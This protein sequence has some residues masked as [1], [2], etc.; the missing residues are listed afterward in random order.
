M[1]RTAAKAGRSLL[2]TAL[3]G[4]LV[5]TAVVELAPAA[6][7]ATATAPT[8][9]RPVPAVTVGATPSLAVTEVVTGLANP[10]DL[11]FLPDGSMIYNERPGRIWKRTPNGAVSQVSADLSDLAVTGEVGLMGMVADPD[12]ATNRT[13]YTCQGH[14]NGGSN[15]ADVRVVRWQFNPALTAATRSGEP[16]VKGIPQ[17]ANYHAGCRLRF[18]NDK[19]LYISTGDTGSGTAPQNLQS[20][21]GKVLRVS[22]NGAVPSGNP[23]ASSSDANTRLVFTRGH[24]NPQGLALR[25]GTNEM[26]SVEQGTDRD[27]EIN[28]LVPGGNY[29][30]NPRKP[31]SE[32]YD[33]STP[34]TN[35]NVPSAIA[36]VFTTGYPT[37]AL[38]GGAWLSG[39]Q[40]G[41]WNG[42]F[43]AAALKNSSIRVLSIAGQQTV[44]NI[45]N[46]GELNGTYGRLRSP[47]Q[48]P[49]GALYITTDNSTDGKI[50]RVTPTRQSP[51]DGRCF[52]ANSDASAP[53]SLVTTGSATTAYVIGAGGALFGRSIE[54]GA[55]FVNLGGSAQYGPGAVTWDGRRT[56]VFVVG[57]NSEL[58]HRFTA[59][60]PWSGWESLGGALTSSPVAVSF[61][62]GT[63]DVMGRGSDNSLW[64]KRWTGSAWTD[65]AFVGGQLIGAPGAA[66]D[67]DSMRGTVGVRGVDGELYELTLTA[68][69]SFSGFTKTGVPICSSPSY[70]ARAG[71]GESF[72]W[73]FAD[74]DGGPVRV[75]GD[76]AGQLGGSIRGA[77]ATTATS[78]GGYAVTGRGL[79]GSLWVFDARVG[80][81]VW[82]S[83]GG[84]IR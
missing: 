64:S 69:G 17:T 28:R 77:P 54:P 5:A 60:G 18:D 68:G 11:F 47:L 16:L 59:G 50:L 39:T 66:V 31:P 56:D 3:I 1:V 40:W 74:R 30:W 71:D 14:V 65:W 43:V 52:A 4:A 35:P 19:L 67:P 79:D 63:L 83:L 9:A 81:G 32:T 13:F 24:R 29:G 61:A 73:V 23:Y 26:W 76:S 8:A 34:M 21:N 53:T 75:V 22:R 42:A 27:D 2:A 41:R 7:A 84:Q 51:G 20:L 46:P 36:A 82:R 49:D 33:Q 38:S 25:P 70:S 45:D 58:Y 44:V 78:G 15:P 12:F 6:T 57:T 80:S 62:N 10:W 72:D 55:P 37:L 48:G